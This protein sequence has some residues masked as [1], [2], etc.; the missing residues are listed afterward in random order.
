MDSN[1]NSYKIFKVNK[2]LEITWRTHTIPVNEFQVESFKDNV[3]TGKKLTLNEVN[4]WTVTFEKLAVS[5]TLG[6]VNHNYT[7]KEVGEN[8]N[9]VR[10]GSDSYNVSFSGSMKDSFTIT[11]KKFEISKTLKPSTKLSKIENTIN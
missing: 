9:T 6:G 2:D 3:S 7:V 8:W 1:E 10:F 4:N 11:N 5:A